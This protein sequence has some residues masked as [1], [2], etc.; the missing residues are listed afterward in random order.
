M[1]P[2]TPSSA[3]S[4]IELS[5]SVLEG[6]KSNASASNREGTA[7]PQGDI[8]VDELLG[9]ISSLESNLRNLR[10]VGIRYET[11]YFIGR[12]FRGGNATAY[13][14]EPTWAIGLGEEIALRAN[15]PIPDVEGYVRQK[16]DVAFLIAKFY[17]SKSQEAEVK[18]AARD[19]KPLP[20]PKPN[21]ETIRLESEE[22]IESMEAFIADQPT[23]KEHFPKFNVRQVMSAPYLFWYHFRSPNVF[24]N[25]KDHHRAYML[26]LT[27]WIEDNYGE[28]YS[29][30]AKQLE[31]GVVSYESLEYT[32]K[33]GDAFIITNGTKVEA[34]IATSLLIS[35][36]PKQFGAEADMP[37]SKKA[38]E[39][40]KKYNWKWTVDCW[41]WRFD[42]SFFKQENSIEIQMHADTLDEEVEIHTLNAYPLKY[43][44]DET[45]SLLEQRGRTIWSC[46][47]RRLVSYEDKKGIYGVWLILRI[48]LVF[49]AN[50]S[51]E[52]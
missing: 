23:F 36:T 49:T 17:T 50:S 8:L 14:D 19:M 3:A 46:R 4:K 10:E 9:R 41:A 39:T 35:R 18:K 27:G 25:L 30:V 16:Q 1:S 13:L 22:M 48:V 6:L 33:P 20:S 45:R 47:D 32:I 51:L 38:K 29:R 44:S 12:D 34:Q 15:F 26:K 21:S 37:W 2:N 24:D 7:V 5:P 43:A 31:R 52:C 42:G 40:K 28:T 11:L